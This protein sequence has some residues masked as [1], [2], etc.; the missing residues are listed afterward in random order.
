[1]NATPKRVRSVPGTN[2][3]SP[4]PGAK[5][6]T[7]SESGKFRAIE[8]GERVPARSPKLVQVCALVF[9]T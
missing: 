4:N 3:P 8:S 2:D 5:K 7:C 9:L 1:M 6:K